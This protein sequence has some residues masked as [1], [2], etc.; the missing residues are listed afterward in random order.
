MTP[1]QDHVTP[2]DRLGTSLEAKRARS[3]SILRS[4]GKYIA[5]LG[6]TFIPRSA[7]ATDVRLTW[8]EAKAEAHP[9]RITLGVPSLLSRQAA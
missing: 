9:Q 1:C 8:A 5:D 2:A 4:R 3:I 6:C 7:A